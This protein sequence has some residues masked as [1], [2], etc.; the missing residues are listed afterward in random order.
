MRQQRVELFVRRGFHAP[1]D[2]HQPLLRMDFMELAS[3]EQ[4]VDRGGIGGGRMRAGKQVV[5]AS[6]CNGTNPV[7][8]EIVVNLHA[9]IAGEAAQAIP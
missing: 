1:Q 9:S 8:H 4:R 2:I 6:Q 7:L 5:L 3:T